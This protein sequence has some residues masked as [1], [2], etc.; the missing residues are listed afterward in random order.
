MIER[1]CKRFLLRLSLQHPSCGA[2]FCDT[3]MRQKLPA[4]CVQMVPGAV[5]EER[6]QGEEEGEWMRIRDECRCLGMVPVRSRQRVQNYI[7][8]L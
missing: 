7:I 4:I 5:K 6:G 8:C 2:T 1:H 3:V